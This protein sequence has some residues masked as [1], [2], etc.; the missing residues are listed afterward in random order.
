[1]TVYPKIRVLIGENDYSW[2][3]Q[4]AGLLPASR[5]HV[6]VIECDALAILKDIAAFHPDIIVVTAQMKHISAIGLLEMCHYWNEYSP[7]FIVIHSQHNLHLE[8]EVMSHGAYCYIEKPFTFNLICD[9][10]LEIANKIQTQAVIS[11]SSYEE[12][13][14]HVLW[15][16]KIPANM[17]GFRCLRQGILLGMTQPAMLESIT[18]ELYPAIAKE[19]NSTTVSVERS[20]RNAIAHAWSECDTS[21]FHTYFGSM[22]RKPSNGQFISMIAERLRLEFHLSDQQQA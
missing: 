13:I 4:C 19:L 9:Y 22:N 6:H 11:V 1:M 5:F 12:R 10:I 20:I 14:S 16:M 3:M 15:E 18:K 2:G 17:K 21:V 8:Q 7:K